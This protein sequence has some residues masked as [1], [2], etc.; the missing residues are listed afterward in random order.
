M[1]TCSLNF[2]YNQ[3][4]NCKIDFQIVFANQ[5]RILSH[6]RRRSQ[7]RLFKKRK[8]KERNLTNWK[9]PTREKR[10]RKEQLLDGKLKMMIMSIICGGN[11]KGK[12]PEGKWW[13]D[14]KNKLICMLLGD[15]QA[16][17]QRKF[18]TTI[19]QNTG[20]FLSKYW[21]LQ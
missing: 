21:R 15:H 19:I 8:S 1:D 5:N 7:W 16:L 9:Q 13:G 12:K 11:I 4:L 3:N 20:N 10:N 18:T 14:N 2:G 6:V 17:D